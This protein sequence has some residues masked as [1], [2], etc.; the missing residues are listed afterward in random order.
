MPM[1]TKFVRVVNI[2]YNILPLTEDIWTLNEAAS[3]LPWEAPI[4][5]VTWSFDHTS[6][7]GWVINWKIYISSFTRLMTIKLGRVLTSGRMFKTYS[8]KSSPTIKLGRVLTS[9]RRLRMHLLKSS[10]TSCTLLLHIFYLSCF[11]VLNLLF[12]DI[13][14]FI[15]SVI[16]CLVNSK[17]KFYLVSMKCN[18]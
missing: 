8:L 11:Y 9:G 15:E 16:L 3:D 17:F 18:K 4:I 10:P 2:K 12:V 13:I 5:N 1:V 14:D 6:M 7:W